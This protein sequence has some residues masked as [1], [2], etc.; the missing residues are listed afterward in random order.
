MQKHAELIKKNLEREVNMLKKLDDPNLDAET[1][2]STLGL[3]R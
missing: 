2:K 1:L 3:I